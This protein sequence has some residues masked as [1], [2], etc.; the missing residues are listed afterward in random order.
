VESL[1]HYFLE[2]MALDHQFIG[3]L[4]SKQAAAA[5]FLAIKTIHDGEW[6]RVI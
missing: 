2:L 4:P 5:Y 1:C 3:C 6:V